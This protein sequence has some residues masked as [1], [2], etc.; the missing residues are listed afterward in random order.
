M[1]GFAPGPPSRPFVFNAPPRPGRET[2][3]AVTV[4]RRNSAHR[5]AA[6]GLISRSSDDEAI[7]RIWALSGP[8]CDRVVSV[9]SISFL[10]GSG[11]G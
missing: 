10:F 8:R 6:S 2:K 11:L 4:P 1:F 3:E 5:H 9:L 7:L